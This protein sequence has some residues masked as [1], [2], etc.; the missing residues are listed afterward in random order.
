MLHSRAVLYTVKNSPV[1]VLLIQIG[2]SYLA[3]IFAKFASKV[4]IQGF[5]FA[6]P[7]CAVVP[8]TVTLMLS[9]K[10]QNRKMLKRCV[11]S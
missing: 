8:V 1:W 9:G 6:F 11:C 4:Q 2:A 5:S 7:L 3:Y 10:K